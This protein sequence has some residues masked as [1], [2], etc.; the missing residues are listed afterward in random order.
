MQYWP[1]TS[2]S[3]AQ[4]NHYLRIIFAMFLEITQYPQATITVLESIQCLLANGRM[5]L[6]II[7]E[8]VYHCVPYV[9]KL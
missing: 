6:V 2:N 3:A 9:E 1:Y 8:A 7:S 5:L 4:S